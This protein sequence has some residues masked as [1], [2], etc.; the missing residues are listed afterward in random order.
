MKCI[1]QL[2]LQP[3]YKKKLI[4]IE[5]REPLKIFSQCVSVLT[6]SGEWCDHAACRDSLGCREGQNFSRFR[7]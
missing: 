3:G 5:L 6:V 1:Q 7:M 2:K 4:L